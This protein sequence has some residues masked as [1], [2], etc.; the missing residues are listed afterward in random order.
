MSSTL[1]IIVFFTGLLFIILIHE[2]GHYTVARA[3][4]FKVEEYFV[5]FGPKVWSFRRGE[6]EYGIKGLPLG[7]YVKIAGMNPYEPVAPEDLPRSYGAKPIWQ[8]ALTIFA[9][10][11]SHFV[12]AALLFA[13]W[14]FFFGD[15]RTGAVVVERVERSLNG[16]AGPASEGGLLAGDVIVGLGDVSDPAPEQVS[17]ILTAQARDRPGQPLRL[18]VARG[19]ATVELSLVPELSL[20]PIDGAMVGRVG[21]VLAPP[22]GER[23]GVIPSL[24]G[25]VKLVGQSIRESFAQIGRVFG[26]QGIGRIFRLLFTDTPRATTDSTSVVGIGQQVGATGAAGDWGT[27]LYFL[28]FVTVFIGLLNLIPLPPFDGGHLMVLGIEKV[29]GRAIDM[30]KLIP[31]SAAVMAFFVV[32]VLATVILDFTKPI[33]AP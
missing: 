23:Q 12:V 7:G 4:G 18:T 14:L 33:P 32:F 13:S 31:V 6:I 21:M 20:S 11:G 9:G 2:G 28:A 17:Q 5:G 19:A 30:R 15:P 29:R 22:E 8:R 10:P 3:F 1:A 24:I 25:G 27:V 16:H 26:P